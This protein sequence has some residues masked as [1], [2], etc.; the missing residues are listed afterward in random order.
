MVYGQA[1]PSDPPGSE[2][3]PPAQLL[4]GTGPGKPLCCRRCASR[5]K[6]STSKSVQ[7]HSRYQGALCVDQERPGR[8]LPRRRCR[9]M[10]GEPCEGHWLGR[11]GRKPHHRVLQQGP[12]CEHG[13][14][15]RLPL[16]ANAVRRGQDYPGW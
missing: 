8:G 12:A 9:P 10:Y 2:F 4:V 15:T 1:E 3:N 16:Q 7:V 13:W 5:H 14:T 6:S 11:Q